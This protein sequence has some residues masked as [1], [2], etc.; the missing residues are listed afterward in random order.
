MYYHLYLPQIIKMEAQAKEDS[1]YQKMKS[2][3]Y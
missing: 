2:K 1:I 3:I